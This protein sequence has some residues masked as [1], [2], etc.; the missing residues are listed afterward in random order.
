MSFM[1]SLLGAIGRSREKTPQLRQAVSQQA[2]RLQGAIT[3]EQGRKESTR[4]FNIREA[5]LQEQ[6][7]DEKIEFDIQQ[8]RMAAKEKQRKKEAERT[9]RRL[10]TT[11]ELNII[12]EINDMGEGVVTDT[13]KKKTET[14]KQKEFEF[15]I[16]KA[17]HKTIA[18]IEKQLKTKATKEA[19]KR[20]LPKLAKIFA[21]KIPEEVAVDMAA[22]S[23][24]ELLGLIKTY[25]MSA[26]KREAVEEKDR[27]K[28]A[29]IETKERKEQF[30]E[31][32][33]EVALNE[34]TRFRGMLQAPDT[35][36][37]HLPGIRQRIQKLKMQPGVAEALKGFMAVEN[38]EKKV[39]NAP[40][41]MKTFD[42]AS[43]L[44]KGDLAEFN[45]S[46]REGTFSG[47]DNHIKAYKSL[48][49]SVVFQVKTAAG[50]VPQYADEEA[51]QVALE[52][53]VNPLFA[54]LKRNPKRDVLKGAVRRTWDKVKNVA[55]YI[56]PE[57]FTGLGSGALIDR[58]NYDDV[59]NIFEFLAAKC[60]TP[61]NQQ[62]V[63]GLFKTWIKDQ[64][65]YSPLF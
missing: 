15:K 63:M 5:R 14:R 1:S 60:K 34:L 46:I 35:P 61:A 4:Q 22:H 36:A 29:A 30:E 50:K 23:P 19:G 45:R 13:T 11:M 12:K 10:Q 40:N 44:L 56:I 43:M 8:K 17:I 65:T 52:L 21:S 20:N 62:D 7:E 41:A 3:A 39:R 37:E 25:M 27:K 42:V 16:S 6:R 24:D 28:L 47:G 51:L 59:R 31:K 38:F 32:K 2:S 26:E 55:G 33:I 49:D 57:S 58:Q 18:T 9:A 48:K 54:L 53:T 64:E